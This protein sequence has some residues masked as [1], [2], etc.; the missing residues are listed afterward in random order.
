MTTLVIGSDTVGSDGHRGEVLALVVDPAA[1]TVTH[2]VVE[3]H[4]RAGLA[5]LV[6]LDLADLADSADSADERPGQI[7]LRC[8]EAEFMSLEAAEETLAEFVPGYR[9]RSSCFPP[10]G[11]VRAGPPPTAARSCGSMK[12]KPSTLSRRARWKSTV[13]TACTP[14]TA[15]PG[16][17]APCASTRAAAG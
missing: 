11:A 14:P 12:R 1:R 6:P 5:R 10:A 16:T 8:T 2:L 15:R 17:C 4:G 9:T 7:R 13:A 3:P